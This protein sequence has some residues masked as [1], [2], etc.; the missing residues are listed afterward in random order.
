MLPSSAVHGDTSRSASN[1]ESFALVCPYSLTVTCRWVNVCRGAK[2]QRKESV[3]PRLNSY[4]ASYLGRR[5]LG[6]PLPAGGHFTPAIN[7]SP[8]IINFMFLPHCSFHV[9]P[10]E[11]PQL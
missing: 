4:L 11:T 7:Y 3:S 9:L 5:A 1:T 2:G 8:G 6:L 10:L